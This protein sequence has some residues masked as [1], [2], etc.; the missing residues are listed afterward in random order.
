V[1]DAPRERPSRR[2]PPLWDGHT[3]ERIIESLIEEGI[4]DEG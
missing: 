2:M 4:S 1:L 3:A